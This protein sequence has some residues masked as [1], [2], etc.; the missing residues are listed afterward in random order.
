MAD[1]TPLPPPRP[2]S[3]PQ[4]A[5]AAPTATSKPALDATARRWLLVGAV[6][7]GLIFVGSL[8]PWAQ[9]VSI[10]GTASVSGTTGDGKLTLVVAALVLAGFLS[11]VW[12]LRWVGAGLGLAIGAYDAWNASS[13]FS[14][15]NESGVAHASVGWGLWLVIGASVGALLAAALGP[16][17]ARLL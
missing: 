16:R 17:A 9:V 15:V 5:A 1:P 13:K 4:A 7:G 12:V 6:C 10:F 14:D 11:S 3:A 2:L 8:G